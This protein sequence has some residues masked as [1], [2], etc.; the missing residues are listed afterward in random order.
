MKKRIIGIF[1]IIMLFQI[2][3][4]KV[5]AASANASIS[6]STTNTVVGNSGT[7][8]LTI[9]SNVAIGQV[10]GTFTCGG[11]GSK[12]LTYSIGPGD[13]PSNS[14]SY[15]IHWKAGSAGT[16]TCE[17]KG[18]EV[19]TLDVD[20]PS[21]S[22]SPKNITVVKQS[23][24][25]GSSS[26]SNSSGSKPSSNK[27][28]SGGT[29]SNKKEYSSDNTLSSLGIDGYTLDPE[30]NK[31]TVE[32][33]ISV[34]ESVEKINITAAANDKKA[35]ITGVGEKNL[36]SGE[37][38]IEVKVTAEN[39]NEKVYKIIVKVED[40]KPIF[41]KIDK[42]EYTIIKKNN[43]LI[44]KLD[45]YEEKIIKINNQDVIS[46]QNSVTK[47]TLVLLKD[48][49][50]KIGYYVYNEK[51]KSYKKYRAITIQGITL[52]LLE[53]PN[54]LDNYQKYSLKLQEEVIDFYK[55]DKKHKVGLIYGTNIKTGNTSYYMYDENESTLSKYFEEEIKIYQKEIEK[56][57]N[58]MMIFIGSTS[59]I[60][61]IIIIISLVK[62]KKSK[63]RRI[64][65]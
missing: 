40:L 56:L 5:F 19:G 30:F 39:G 32:Y 27:G 24:S 9:S 25:G 53:S 17:A 10:Y 47:V 2:P 31:D 16:F 8:T 46:Y 34:D 37:N 64:K 28:N 7:A 62:S 36:S 4:T 23:S 43:G 33:K 18:L 14:R 58:Y 6:V 52:Q 35:T 42:E 49:E 1:I 50:N 63:K 41:V 45:Q 11:L 38:T 13:T 55:L 12:D 60:A 26:N 54:I 22:V 3:T 48:K 57:K 21:V 65:Y 44:E 59:F 15:T 51:E 29:T 20:W 61:I